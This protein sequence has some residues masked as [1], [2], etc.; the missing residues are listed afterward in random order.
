MTKSSNGRKAKNLQ[1]IRNANRASVFRY[2]ALNISATRSDLTRY[3][4]L[5][6]MAISN[7]VS[8]LL[9][10][11]Y[12]IELEREEQDTQNQSAQIRTAGRKSLELRLQA[13]K[14]AALGLYLS[15]DALQAVIA[16]ITGHIY[17]S[18][19]QDLPLTTE[20]TAAENVLLLEETFANMAALIK[21]E[22][23]DDLE[24]L[25][26]IGAGLCSIG[27]LDIKQGILLDPPNFYGLEM[28]DLQ[29]MV[30][31]SFE[32][33]VWLD[34]DMNAAAW[35]EHLYGAACGQQHCLYIG[36][37][38]GIG[39]GVIAYGRIF[40]GSAGYGGE[41]GH[42]SIQMDGPVCYC[43]RRGCLETYISLPVLLN[44]TGSGSLDELIARS[45]DHKF[46]E[47]WL[48]EF[49]Q[50]LQTGLINLVN[51]FDPDIILLGHEGAELVAEHIEA[52]ESEVN[53]GIFQKKAHNVKI[54]LAEHM[55]KAPLY[56]SASLVF[57]AV[58]RGD[59]AP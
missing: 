24:Q 23:R 39:A 16:D 34:N 18:W 48:P 56:G 57:Q 7:I 33:P 32:L 40:Q 49:M 50:A 4:G 1:Y 29:A 36:L 37:T 45:R 58:F 47:K 17:K 6:K 22:L 14:F 53:N 30:S 55:E 52:L 28:I 2:L 38:N 5:S 26:I 20:K 35:A 59:L 3:L 12:L 15:R 44:K 42:M 21:S 43:G 54:R 51:V 19:K 41:V 9:E 10:E 11:K 27:P 13:D 46:K 25:S 8:E 31:R